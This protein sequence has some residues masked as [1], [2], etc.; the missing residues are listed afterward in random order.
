ME[1]ETRIIKLTL[2]TLSL[3]NGYF[4]MSWGTVQT[5]TPTCLFYLSTTITIKKFILTA[6]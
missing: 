4:E 3:Y 2:P 6:K 5:F 1:E